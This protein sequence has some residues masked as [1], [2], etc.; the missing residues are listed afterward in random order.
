MLQ[1]TAQTV[2]EQSAARSVI[3]FTASVGNFLMKTRFSHRVLRV[4]ALFLMIAVCPRTLFADSVEDT[5]LAQTNARIDQL[6]EQYSTLPRQPIIF[7]AN[8]FFA[9]GSIVKW[10]P[11][12]DLLAYA[13][14]LKEAGVQR[15]DINPGLTSMTDPVIVAK[16][17][18]LVAHIRALGLKL[19]VNVQ[20]SPSTDGPL[21]GFNQYQSDALAEDEQIAER[22]HPDNFVL[23]HEPSTMNARMGIRVSPDQWRDFIVATAA[24]VKKASPTTRVGAGCYAQPN[25]LPY[26]EEFSQIPEV[27]FLT[28]D[29]YADGPRA[30]NTL[31]RMTTIAHQAGKPVYMEETWRPHMLAPGWQSQNLHGESMDHVSV[32]GVGNSFFE[33]LDG[34]WLRTMAMYAATHGM[35]AITPFSTDT[36]FLYVDSGPDG[37]DSPDYI[38]QVQQAI[39][40][41]QRT[42]TFHAYQQVIQEFSK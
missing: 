9:H 26:F 19:A 17:D 7:S 12:E 29:N 36:F 6:T 38:R 25:E 42:S 15:V 10:M 11:T 20:Y 28:A 1:T 35:E 18:A 31:D 41:K 32:K 22:Y 30:M 37:E 39:E 33:Q 14:A 13:D 34:K 4:L 16:Y 3:V 40:Q 21:T 8:L 2:I 27:D 23:V 24:V 5:F